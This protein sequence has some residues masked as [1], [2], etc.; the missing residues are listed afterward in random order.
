MS[1]HPISAGTLVTKHKILTPRA[2][3]AVN[4]LR[5]RGIVFTI[6]SG[7]P[8]RGIRMLSND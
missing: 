3:A 4:Q 7:R 2:I 8:A 1:D 6:C 5:E